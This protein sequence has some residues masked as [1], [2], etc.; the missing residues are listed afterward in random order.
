MGLFDLESMTT[1]ADQKCVVAGEPSS[2]SLKRFLVLI[3]LWF[4]FFCMTRS[5]KDSSLLYFAELEK[6]ER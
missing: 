1:T 5:S 2:F 3:I 6:E 4:Y